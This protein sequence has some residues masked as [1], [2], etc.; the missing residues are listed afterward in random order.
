M[1]VPITVGQR[2]REQSHCSVRTYSTGSLTFTPAAGQ[3]G[4][5]K[6]TVTVRDAGLN[7]TLGDGDDGLV[8]KSFTVSVLSPDQV[9]HV[10]QF[11]ERQR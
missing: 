3:T 11:F 1:I 6:I 8:S 7:G 2:F 4:T 10:D 5:A 9:N